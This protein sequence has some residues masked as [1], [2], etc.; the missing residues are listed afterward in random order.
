MTAVLGPFT[1][2]SPMDSQTYFDIEVAV[3]VAVGA[4]PV[5][6][7]T[8]DASR[9]KL[10]F[11]LQVA[12]GNDIWI[13]P[14]TDPTLGALMYFLY[15]PSAAETRQGLHCDLSWQDDPFVI[16]QPWFAVAPFGGGVVNATAVRVT[17]WPTRPDMAPI[18]PIHIPKCPEVIQHGI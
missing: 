15:F 18:R 12:F 14:G 3:N 10:H 2:L 7:F 17:D 16:S 11:V 9:I 5:Q 1:D 4:T 6:I 13:G 8:A